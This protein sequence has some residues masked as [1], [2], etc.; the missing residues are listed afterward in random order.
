LCPRNSFVARLRLKKTSA[1]PGR[2]SRLE[3]TALA[4]TCYRRHRYRE[5]SPRRALPQTRAGQLTCQSRHFQGFQR[6]NKRSIRIALPPRLP[7]LNS[8]L[9]RHPDELGIGPIS[10]PSGH[11]RVNCF[12]LNR[13][14]LGEIPVAFT[15]APADRDELR[16]FLVRPVILESKLDR[17]GRSRGHEFHVFGSEMQ[18]SF[19]TKCPLQS[20]CRV[21]DS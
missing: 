9:D 14:L 19:R 11:F 10:H 2:S 18:S 16:S 17:A 15:L 12:S 3:S 6:P 7:P 20:N 5:G 8:I 21:H 13:V 1:V 4:D